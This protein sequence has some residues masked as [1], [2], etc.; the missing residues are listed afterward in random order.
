MRNL[1]KTVQ[2]T[3]INLENGLKINDSIFSNVSITLEKK[4]ATL[5]NAEGG[6]DESPFVYWFA[7][8]QMK[9]LRIKT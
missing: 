3:R 1:T 2:E 4:S 5:E 7:I 8:R 6:S 9:P